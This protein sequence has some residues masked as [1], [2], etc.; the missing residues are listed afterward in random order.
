M[1]HPLRR[2]RME[3]GP[4]DRGVGGS[5]SPVDKILKGSKPADLPIEHATKF[6]G[7]VTLKTA[8]AL[9]VRLQVQ[10]FQAGEPIE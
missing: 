1:H 6:D 4:R 8:T 5:A 2:A 3:L 10:L 7:R 9:E